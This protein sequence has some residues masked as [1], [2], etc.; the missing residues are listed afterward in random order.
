[1]NEIPL[2]LVIYVVGAV[3]TG[4]CLLS[5]SGDESEYEAW[6]GIAVATMLWPLCL[7]F[8]LLYAIIRAA[9]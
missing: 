1:M 7:P 6:G 9:R 2:M 5:L 4:A 8:L 3:I